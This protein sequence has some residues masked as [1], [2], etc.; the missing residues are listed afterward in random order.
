MKKEAILAAVRFATLK[1]TFIVK[2]TG[3]LFV[4]STANL[5]L[6]TKRLLSRL[7]SKEPR[8]NYSRQ[9][10]S[11]QT[12]LYYTRNYY[13]TLLKTKPITSYFTFNS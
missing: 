11:I 2:S 4:V 9:L 7:N 13:R 3:F 8:S 12:I 5:N 6:I 10:S 1:L